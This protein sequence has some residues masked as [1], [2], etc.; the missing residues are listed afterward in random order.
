MCCDLCALL[1]ERERRVEEKKESRFIRNIFSLCGRAQAKK[2][3][4]RTNLRSRSM[5]NIP[6]LFQSL[7]QWLCLFFLDNNHHARPKIG[8]PNFSS[9]SICSQRIICVCVCIFLLLFFY[10]Y[11][12]VLLGNSSVGVVGICVFSLPMHAP[13]WLP[14][15]LLLLSSRIIAY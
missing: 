10:I 12:S 4:T 5:E 13:P 11:Q 2:T 3:T 14:S 7:Y 6:L 8:A 1:E 9:A 15:T